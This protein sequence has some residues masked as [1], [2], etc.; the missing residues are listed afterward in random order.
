[1]GYARFV[2]NVQAVLIVQAPT[3]FLPRV[4]GEDEGEGLNGAKRLNVL[5]GLN[6]LNILLAESF[7]KSG[8]LDFPHDSSIGMVLGL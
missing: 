1:M 3:S 5:N 8:L 6:D 7:N 4:A 2:Q